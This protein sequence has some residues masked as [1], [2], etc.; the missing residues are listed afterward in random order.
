M[1]VTAK[2]FGT[3]KKGE[4][5]TLYTIT[6]KCGTEASVMDFGAT[7]VSFKMKDKNGIIKDLVL[8]FD[9][10]KPYLKDGNLFGATVGPIANRTAK[11]RFTLNGKEYRLKANDGEN[12]LHTSHKKGFQKCLF[13]ANC[14]DNSVTFSIKKEDMAMGHPGNVDVQVTY[15]LSEDNALEIKYHAT[16]DKDTYL[17][18]TN[19]SYFNLNGHDAAPIFHEKV[20]IHA[21]S[22]TPVV[23]G[24][25]PTGEI[26]PVAGTP[27]DF[28]EAKEV[29]RDFTYGFEQ[30][31]LVNGYDHNFVLDCW[32]GNVREVALVTDDI[33]GIKMHV[34]TDLPGV[35]FYTGNW[36]GV[37]KAKGG[38]SYGP[39][40]GLCLETQYYPNCV[41][42]E[43]FPKP[44]CGPEKPFDS[45]TVY[46]FEVAAE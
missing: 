23:K 46:R 36:V 20:Q 41:N 7:L 43:C 34:L 12:N 39:R 32:D 37:G 28:T 27:M 40:Q 6:N 44:L 5:I 1:G 19:H 33:S 24:A 10:A 30:I 14:K 42:E 45:V 18:L 22:Y 25:I 13:K 2:K 26:A 9:E 21:K 3:T 17:N 15:T 11:A 4:K 35:Q 38:V 29:C 8:G 31:E 16:S